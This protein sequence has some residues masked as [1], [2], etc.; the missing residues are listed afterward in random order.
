MA[1]FE[2]VF[3]RIKHFLRTP[4]NSERDL[5]FLKNLAKSLINDF[6]LERAL[7]SSAI[8]MV[9]ELKFT[10]FNQA[11]EV[12]ELSGDLHRHY[13]VL[14]ACGGN[15]TP[16]ALI[17]LVLT[18]PDPNKDLVS[19]EEVLAMM[20]QP[21]AFS[22]TVPRMYQPSLFAAFQNARSSILKISL[23]TLL[24]HAGRKDCLMKYINDG[25]FGDRQ[26][27]ETKLD[28]VKRLDPRKKGP[29]SDE[30]ILVL[31]LLYPDRFVEVEEYSNIGLRTLLALDIATEGKFP[32]M[33][34]APL[35]WVK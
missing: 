26:T 6:G 27:R 15:A 33:E 13:A 20:A 25:Y 21:L 5:E 3:S 16:T 24:Y 19:E 14:C 28:Q 9:G 8:N 22:T 17:S 1:D 18:E 11:I 4:V 12:L 2:E 10:N 34:L 30:D 7:G 29:F 35:D 31:D 23:A 32:K